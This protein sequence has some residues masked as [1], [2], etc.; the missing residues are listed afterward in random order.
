[1]GGS[2]SYL[3]GFL[4]QI[5]HENICSITAVLMCNVLHFAHRLGLHALSK[6]RVCWEQRDNHVLQTSQYYFYIG[7]ELVARASL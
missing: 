5:I 6:P 3:D 2:R 4:I 1:M 7:T